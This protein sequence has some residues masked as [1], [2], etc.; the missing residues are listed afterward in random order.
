MFGNLFNNKFY[1]GKMQ[2]KPLDKFRQCGPLTML[3]AV[4]IVLFGVSSTALTTFGI[5]K[6]TNQPGAPTPARNTIS[7]IDH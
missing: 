5:N 3:F 1:F 7:L 2:H 6:N 4:F